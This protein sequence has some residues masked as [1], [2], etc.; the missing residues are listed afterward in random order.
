M[1]YGNGRD[2]PATFHRL[3]GLVDMLSEV[4]GV[5]EELVNEIREQI[6]QDQY[7]TEEKLNG[8]IHRL[9]REI[10]TDEEERVS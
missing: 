8:A 1:F 7:L 6:D 2:Y 9:L 10:M 3:T 4:D 5:R